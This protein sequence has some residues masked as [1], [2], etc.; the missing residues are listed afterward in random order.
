MFVNLELRGKCKEMAE[1]AVSSDPTLT[2]VRGHYWCPLWGEQAHWWTV[3][4]DGTIFDPTKDQ[5]PSRGNGHYEPFRGWVTCSECGTDVVEADAIIDGN[6]HYAF[7]SGRCNA[8]FVG[9]E[10]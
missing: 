3:R 7:C 8:R 5:F 9:I 1:S 6:G 10:V 4:Q 2:L